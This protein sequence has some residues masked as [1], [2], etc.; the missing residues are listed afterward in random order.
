MLV[1]VAE[2]GVKNPSAAVTLRLMRVV[3]AAGF[4]ALIVSTR[5]QRPETAP[6]RAE[7]RLLRNVARAARALHVRV[8]L[9]VGHGLSGGTPR[10]PEERQQLA[11]FAAVYARALPSVRDFIVDNEPNLNTF[12]MPQ[13]DGG[14]HDAAA[15]AY[16]DLLARTY[17][18]L[19]AIS[20]RI[21]VIGG[22]LASR[23]LDRP[24]TPRDT[25]SPTVFI[26]DLGGAYRASG[27][28]R[29]IMD[30]LA[31][32]PYMGS[33]A[34]PPTL[35]HRRSKTITFADYPR[36]TTLLG[37]TFDGTAQPGS[38]LPIFYTEFGVQSRISP[39]DRAGYTDLAS[40]TAR[41]AVSEPTQ[42]AYYR[43]ALALAF[44][45]PS[46]RGVFVFHVWDE[47]DLRGWQSGLYYVDRRP[48]SS[49]AAFRDAAAAVRAG[50]IAHCG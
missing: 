14:G 16:F 36:L 15:A 46:V 4:D 8:F 45:Q 31:L 34:I 5:W 32:H 42:S 24:G 21:D 39:R 7:L 23:G 13:F 28:K 27:R 17:D 43:Q 6:P 30:A 1:G 40:P 11:A 22:A 37:E 18:A 35:A 9:I 48:K 10:T 47:P 20:P 33:S 29:P 44:C 25:H 2:D 50:A 38:R 3:R 19:K 26:R 49:L 41:D 12:W